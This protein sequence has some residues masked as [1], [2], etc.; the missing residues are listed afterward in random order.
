MCLAQRPQRSDTGEARTHGPSYEVVINIPVAV[1]S[2][3]PALEDERFHVPTVSW[4]CHGCPPLTV[5]AGLVSVG[6]LS[7]QP[8]NQQSGSPTKEP[9]SCESATTV[10]P[11]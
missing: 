10:K 8:L 7:L 11:V 1:Q 2:Q 3:T 6:G 9:N 4:P 5:T